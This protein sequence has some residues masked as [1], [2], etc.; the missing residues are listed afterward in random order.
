MG[1]SRG[2]VS[3]IGGHITTCRSSILGCGRVMQV[4][5]CG[6]DMTGRLHERSGD[7][8]HAVGGCRW[9]LSGAPVE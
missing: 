1:E 8:G 3:C 7:V 9:F 4:T 2:I 6:S 5:T